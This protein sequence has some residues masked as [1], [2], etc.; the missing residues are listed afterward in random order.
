MSAIEDLDP[1]FIHSH[2]KTPQNCPHELIKEATHVI[3]VLLS[4]WS[5]M[6]VPTQKI[7]L[8][9]CKVQPQIEVDQQQAQPLFL[10]RSTRRHAAPVE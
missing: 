10:P 1:P 5:D 8:S 2:E 4:D 7:Y 6:A 3:I 9:S